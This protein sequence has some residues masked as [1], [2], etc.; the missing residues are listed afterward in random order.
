M[1]RY[2]MFLIGTDAAAMY[3]IALKGFHQLSFLHCSKV[4]LPAQG[5]GFREM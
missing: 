1:H 2:K 3:E 5:R 4:K